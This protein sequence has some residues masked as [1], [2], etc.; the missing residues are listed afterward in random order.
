MLIRPIKKT[1]NLAIK[2]IIQGVILEYGAPKVGTAYNDQATHDMYHH[3]QQARRVYFVFEDEGK[4]IG[5]AGVGPLEAA[6]EQYCELQK[7]Y[8]LPQA[9]G[10]GYGSQ[11]MKACLSHATALKYDYIYLETMDN[12]IEA[13]GLY[14]KVG[15]E[16]LE[17]PLGSTGHYSCPVQMIKKL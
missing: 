7:M 15:F 2:E 6:G 9:R 10:K 16:L 12:M 17:K 3:Y 4:V 14:K 13:Q 8:F 1:D 5:G 11:L